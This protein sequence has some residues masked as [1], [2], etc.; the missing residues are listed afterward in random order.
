MDLKWTSNGP[1]ILQSKTDSKIDLIGPNMVKILF[2]KK[3]FQFDFG[4]LFFSGP[5]YSLAKSILSVVAEILAGLWQLLAIE[6]Q[7]LSSTLTSDAKRELKCTFHVSFLTAN[8]Q[9]FK[10]SAS[11]GRKDDRITFFSR[12]KTCQFLVKIS[13]QILC[14]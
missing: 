8:L 13:G 7:F 12:I 10:V 9:N 6:I 5:I 14:P 2:F 1:Q 4:C 11:G 3:N